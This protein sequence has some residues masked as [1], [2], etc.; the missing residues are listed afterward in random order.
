MSDKIETSTRGTGEDNFV[1]SKGTENY[2]SLTSSFIA[3]YFGKTTKTGVRVRNTPES[4]SFTQVVMGSMFYIEGTENGPTIS[5]STSTLWVKVRFGKGDG[6]YVSRYIHS[7]CFGNTLTL[8]ASVKTR[9][10]TIA[11]TLVSNNGNGLDMSG[12]WCQR[13]IYWL[14]SASGMTVTNMPYSEGYCGQARLK[15]V[16]LYGATW[17]QRGDGY[18]PAAGDLIYYG[19]L[20]SDISSHVGLVVTGGSSFSTVEGNIGTETNQSLHKVKTFT[21]SVSTGK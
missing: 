16:N 9:I 18:I 15:M 7:S 11:R 20:N 12:D 19:D 21:G 2:A 5:G 6:T 10:V 13:F 3:G 17:H 8:P 14:C 1:D 4:N